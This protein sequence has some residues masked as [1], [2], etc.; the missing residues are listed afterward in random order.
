MQDE[1]G[2]ENWRVYAVDAASRTTKDLTPFPGVRASI[3]GA[4]PKVKGEI[5]IT[6]NKRDKHYPDLFR[7]DLASGELKLV[8]ENPGFAG[9]DDMMISRLYSP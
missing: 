8:A 2:D 7:V 3:A 9:F 1:G 5:L 6:L 4:S